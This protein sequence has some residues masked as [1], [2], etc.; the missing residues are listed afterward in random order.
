MDALANIV[1]I[2]HLAYFVFVVSGFIAILAAVRS[3]FPIS[4]SG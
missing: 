4:G 3:G 2:F 1:T